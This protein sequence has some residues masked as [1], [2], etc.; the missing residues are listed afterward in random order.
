MQN[1]ERDTWCHGPSEKIGRQRRMSA[2]A[3][4]VA[5]RE[6]REGDYIARKIS[7]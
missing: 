4:G 1:A 3:L 2:L 6:S 7:N 5:A